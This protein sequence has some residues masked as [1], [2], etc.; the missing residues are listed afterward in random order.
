MLVDLLKQEPIERVL[1]SHKVRARVE[2]ME[3]EKAIFL[4]VVKRYSRQIGN[5]VVTDL[6]ELNVLPVG[7]RFLIYTLF[8]DANVSLRLAWG[9]GRKSV[10]ATVGHSIFNRTCQVHVGDLMAKYSGGGH[11]GA[12]ATPLV[13]A[14]ADRLIHQMIEELQEDV[15][16]DE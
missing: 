2:R 11:R 1:A 13:P 9:P 16:A 12:G 10:V 14:V 5:V 4:D 3:K 8:P 15:P 7:N 6:R